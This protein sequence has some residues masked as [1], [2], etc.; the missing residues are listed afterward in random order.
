[1]TTETVT[2][3]D[4]ARAIARAASEVRSS[5][6]DTAAGIVAESVTGGTCPRCSSTYDA[7][8]PAEYCHYVPSKAR[9]TSDGVWFGSVACRG[10]NMR[11]E[12]ARDILGLAAD[13]P[14]P[15]AYVKAYFHVPARFSSRADI[16]RMA[17][18]IPARRVSNV[19]DST[20]EAARADL[21][22]V[23]LI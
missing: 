10:C 20:R 12:A 5:A 17:A 18:G 21:E 14:M 4:Y 6:R 23:G 19:S 13:A 11:D 3:A 15:Y 8:N 16:L 7:G 2:P 1:M 22:A 9:V